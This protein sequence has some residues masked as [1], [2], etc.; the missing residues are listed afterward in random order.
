[1]AR[2]DFS[3]K[4]EGML[5]G[6]VFSSSSPKKNWKRL[7]REK[8]VG[9]ETNASSNLG[10]KIREIADGI[11]SVAEWGVIKLATQR[12]TLI[13]RLLIRRVL[14]GDSHGCWNTQLLKS[15]FNALDVETILSI[16]VDVQ[17]VLRLG[18]L[19]GDGVS[20][21]GIYPFLQR[22]GINC[23]GGCR[24]CSEARETTFHALIDCCGAAEVWYKS[25]F[26]QVIVHFRANILEGAGMRLAEYQA[27][28]GIIASPHSILKTQN[29]K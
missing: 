9:S 8:N 17:Q 29:Y 15:V 19:I 23:S 3:I 4:K 2:A 28:Q 1:M 27:Y 7:A 20:F 25:A 6:F 12:G 21:Y 16:L 11:V 26:W 14:D 10:K 13:R 5:T 24:R 22:R 18:V